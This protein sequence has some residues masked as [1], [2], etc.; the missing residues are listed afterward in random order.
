[1]ETPVKTLDIPIGG[2]LYSAQT[3]P[4]ILEFINITNKIKSDFKNTLIDDKD[5]SATIKILNTTR[6][7]AQRINSMHPSSLGL[8]PI[9]YFYSQEGRHKIASF[10]A[11]VLFVMELEEKN[12]INDFISAREPF[13]SILIEFDFLVQQINRKYRTSAVS[14]PYI[15]N[16]YFR[17]IELLNKGMQKDKVISEIPGDANFNYLTIHPNVDE[18]SS[19]EFSKERKGAVY[20]KD[21][22]KNAIRCKICNG[23]IHKNS[24]TIDHVARKEDGGLGTID[25]GQIAHPYCNSTYKN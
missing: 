23:Y 9:V 22:I 5:G 8:H 24:I 4:L 10:L 17:I 25:N 21:A 14:Y 19:K 12:K 1:M 16:Y 2:K 15:K 7:T 3:L 20:I 18:V 11:T 13:E 6:K